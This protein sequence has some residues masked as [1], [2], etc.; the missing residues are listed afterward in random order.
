M[1]H[2]E[3]CRNTTTKAVRLH[4]LHERLEYGDEDVMGFRFDAKRL[5]SN[6]LGTEGKA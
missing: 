3:W 1:S 4:K 5:A 2:S 6:T